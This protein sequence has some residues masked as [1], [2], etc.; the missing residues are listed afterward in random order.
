LAN[1]FFPNYCITYVNNTKSIPTV[2]TR[3][4]CNFQK[5]AQNKQSPNGLK[6][7]QSGHTEVM[8][9]CSETLCGIGTSSMP[10]PTENPGFLEQKKNLFFAKK[11]EEDSVDVAP[12][13]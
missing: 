5:N 1:P 4:F 10:L 3:C 9:T 11:N 2:H 12:V 6:F 7:A 13:F 8:P